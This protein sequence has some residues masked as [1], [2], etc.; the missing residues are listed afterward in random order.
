[1]THPCSSRRR[2]ALWSSIAA[3]TL[4]LVVAQGA[5]AQCQPHQLPLAKHPSNAQLASPAITR[6][7]DALLKRMTLAEKIGQLVQ[8]CRGYQCRDRGES[9][10]SHPR[11]CDGVG[12]EG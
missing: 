7:V 1:M 2:S 9:G 12:E 10:N 3:C 5:A 4:T 11:R 8:Y 6:K